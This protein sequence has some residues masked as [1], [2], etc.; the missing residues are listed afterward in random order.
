MKPRLLDLP[1][2]E[3]IEAVAQASE[4]YPLSEYDEETQARAR[5]EATAALTVAYPIIAQE[6][7][8]FVREVA[9]HYA[10]VDLGLLAASIERE[11]GGAPC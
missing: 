7:A 2:Q 10:E 3:A 9:E 11:F 8:A 1:S 6:I 4:I 5:K